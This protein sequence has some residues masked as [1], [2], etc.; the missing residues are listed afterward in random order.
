M[1]SLTIDEANK[2][3]HDRW[4]DATDGWPGLFPFTIPVN[5]IDVVIAS[6]YQ[7][8]LK[9]EIFETASD[10]VRLS[11][12]EDGRAQHTMGP[13]PRFRVVGRA[14]IQLFLQQ[15]RG[16]RAGLMIAAAAR[17]IFEK[18]R[19]GDLSF[20]AANVRELGNEGRWWTASVDCPFSYDERRA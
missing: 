11:V 16:G 19:L 7:T 4:F 8:A 17:T 5:D 1:M 13:R 6:A 3:I 10:W 15:D 12:L 18:V 20:F 2:L 9:N 14:T